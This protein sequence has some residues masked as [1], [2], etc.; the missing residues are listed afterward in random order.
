MRR[1]I[2]ALLLV[3]SGACA[4]VNRSVSVGV[5]A[6]ASLSDVPVHGFQVLVRY[7]SIPYGAAAVPGELLAAD[8]RNVYVLATASWGSRRVTVVPRD[9]ID[10]VTVVL[11][12]GRASPG[13]VALWAGAG[14][15]STLSHG[16]VLILSAPVWV[17]AGVVTTIVAA[18]AEGTMVIRD[19]DLLWQYAR[20]P[21]GIP[22]VSRPERPARQPPRER[23]R[24]EARP[25]TNARTST[26][27][28]TPTRRRPFYPAGDPRS[29]PRP[30]DVA[31]RTSTSSTAPPAGP[32][33]VTSTSTVGTSTI[34]AR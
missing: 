15:G 10:E 5:P 30:L 8:D 16:Y 19:L 11:D 25:V 31:P 17:L 22:R 13:G 12:A 3:H 28:S 20:Y 27:T 23:V 7:R 26:S 14:L 4:R 33:P 1:W 34:T 32:P 18:T 24:R 21:Q 9:Q 2:A 6:R 29:A